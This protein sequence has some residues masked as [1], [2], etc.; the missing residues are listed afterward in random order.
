M[1]IMVSSGTGSLF[2]NRQLTST[3][4]VGRRERAFFNRR[5]SVDDT[6]SLQRISMV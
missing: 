4:A 5:L 1:M 6:P 2:L 3:M